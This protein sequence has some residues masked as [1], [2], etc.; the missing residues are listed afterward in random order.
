[1]I[2]GGCLFGAKT[3]RVPNGNLTRVGTVSA[4]RPFTYDHANRKWGLQDF[5]W[6]WPVRT[7]GTLR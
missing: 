1:M 4:G 3:A 2:W 5:A 6:R 7:A